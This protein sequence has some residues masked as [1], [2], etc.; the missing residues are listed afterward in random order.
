MDLGSLTIGHTR[1]AFTCQCF[2]SHKTKLDA[3]YV[4]TSILPISLTQVDCLRLHNQRPFLLSSYLSFILPEKTIIFI[5][6]SVYI[7]TKSTFLISQEPSAR[8][9]RTFF[10]LLLA[11]TAQASL[12][13]I[14]PSRSKPTAVVEN[15]GPKSLRSDPGALDVPYI[16]CPPGFVE[17]RAIIDHYMVCA[18]CPPGEKLSS[19]TGPAYFGWTQGELLCEGGEQVADPERHCLNGATVWEPHPRGCLYYPDPVAAAPQ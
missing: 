7:F 14:S 6:S 8:A 5:I 13:T 16:S 10:I 2:T 19:S 17:S 11:T 9:M 18:C 15:I 1:N 12:T 3:D 4:R